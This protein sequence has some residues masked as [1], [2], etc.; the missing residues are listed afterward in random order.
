MK[1]ILEASENVHQSWSMSCHAINRYE[2]QELSQFTIQFI[3]TRRG[4]DGS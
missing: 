4:I 3:I 2:T 1:L